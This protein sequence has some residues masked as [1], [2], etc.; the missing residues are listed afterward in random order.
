MHLSVLCPTTPPPTGDMWGFVW[1]FDL[2]NL[3]I[4]HVWGKSYKKIP[5]LLR[6]SNHNHLQFLTDLHVH[7]NKTEMLILLLENKIN[8]D[9]NLILVPRTDLS[10]QQICV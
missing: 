2:I 7:S 1:G 8:A 5:L 6:A 3:Q 4:S 10:A 9:S